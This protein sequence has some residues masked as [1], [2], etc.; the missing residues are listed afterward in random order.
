MTT[1]TRIDPKQVHERLSDDADDILLVCAYQD[2]D[3]CR[4]NQLGPAITRKELERRLPKLSK[5]Q[6]LVFYCG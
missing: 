4:E 1:A 6:D 3:K 2:E 5:D